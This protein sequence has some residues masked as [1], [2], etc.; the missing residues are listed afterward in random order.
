MTQ[1]LS[2][3]LVSDKDDGGATTPVARVGDVAAVAP[4]GDVA[5]VARDGD[6]VATLCDRRPSV[7][8]FSPNFC[9]RVSPFSPIG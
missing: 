4:A 9:H 7:S 3:R 5:T 8:P 1:P 2:P 6:G